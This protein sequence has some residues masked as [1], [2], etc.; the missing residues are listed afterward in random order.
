MS[1]GN[2]TVSPSGVAGL[3]M[4]LLGAGVSAP[5]GFAS[6]PFE[7]EMGMGAAS[8]SRRCAGRRRKS[9]SNQAKI[10]FGLRIV[11]MRRRNTK[12]RISEKKLAAQ[13]PTQGDTEPCCAMC[14]PV[15]KMK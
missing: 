5:F 15:T 1:I 3:G 6:F 14:V 11:S 2:D 13:I 9:E 7:T 8:D 4:P 10:R 12:P